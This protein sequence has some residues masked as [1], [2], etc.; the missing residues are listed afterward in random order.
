MEILTLILFV[1]S[2]VMLALGAWLNRQAKHHLKA[3]QQH[4]DDADRVL[5]E[6]ERRISD[7]GAAAL[8][9]PERRT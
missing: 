5:A 4:H 8:A 7:I 9:V 6:V 1:V 3:A 2:I